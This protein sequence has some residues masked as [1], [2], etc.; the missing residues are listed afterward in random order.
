MDMQNINIKN[1]I[2]F[3]I[4][5]GDVFASAKKQKYNRKQN[6]MSIAQKT[7]NNMDAFLE[8]LSKSV[9]ALTS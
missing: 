4:D 3:S 2:N 5:K 9:P 6:V 8:H 1:F 7:G